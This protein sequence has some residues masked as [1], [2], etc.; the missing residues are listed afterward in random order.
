MLTFLLAAALLQPER[1]STPSDLARA[2]D[3][4]QAVACR[5]LAQVY[6]RGEGVARSPG[7][8]ARLYQKA[9]AGGDAE[10][11]FGLGLQWKLGEGVVAADEERGSRLLGVACERGQLDACWTIALER[12]ME[13]QDAADPRRQGARLEARAQLARM[14]D[15]GYAQSC[16]TLS[17]SDATDE[18]GLAD[19]ARAP[20][21]WHRAIRLR[22]RDCEAGV[23]DAC[24]ELARMYAPPLSPSERR[25]GGPLDPALSRRYRLRAEALLQAACEKGDMGSDGCV[26]LGELHVENAVVEYDFE[27]AFAALAKACAAGFYEGCVGLR[28]LRSL[29]GGS[30]GS[31]GKDEAKLQRIEAA[32]GKSEACG[33]PAPRL[34]APEDQPLADDPGST[35]IRD[36]LLAAASD[37]TKKWD[38][39]YDAALGLERMGQ[40]HLVKSVLDFQ[41]AEDTNSRFIVVKSKMERLARTRGSAV[42]RQTDAELLLRE[43]DLGARYKTDAWGRPLR[44]RV[45]AQGELQVLSDGPDKAPGT[46]DDL[47]SDEPYEA[48]VERVFPDLF[49]RP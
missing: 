29:Y 16:Q 31:F 25:P 12:L 27:R 44:A 2:C 40:G 21:R 41:K 46:A 45:L 49:L 8:A 32:C 22:R 19:P 43:I 1:A 34:T 28:D 5:K 24:L 35:E 33:G 37:K 9:C 26:G 36:R 15:L 48:F 39:R 4:G 30:T 18:L 7:R 38:A 14:C 13:H 3:A 42:E 23:A 6:A 20:E 17:T 10:A 11:C 47:F